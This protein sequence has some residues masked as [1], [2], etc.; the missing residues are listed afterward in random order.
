MKKN[1]IILTVLIAMTITTRGQFGTSLSTDGVHDYVVVQDNNALDLTNN[2]TIECWIQANNVES[3]SLLR[4][5]WCNGAD[6]SYYLSVFSGK[7]E[8]GWSQSGN[9]NYPSWYK[10]IDTVVQEGVC[11]HI[12]IVHSNTEVKIYIDN[13]LVPGI[14]ENGNYS[15]VNNSSEQMDIA[16]YRYLSGAYGNFYCG[17]IDEIRFWNYKLTQLEISD[18]SN[19]P[20]NGTEQGLVAYFD[21]EDTGQGTTLTVTNKAIVSGSIIGQAFGTLSSPQFINSC[22]DPIISSPD[23][24][25]ANTGSNHTI[26][27]QTGTVTISGDPISLGDYIG[28]FF[29]DAGNYVC[30]GYS[31]WTG[32]PS[33]AIAA[34][35]DDTSTPD[36]DGFFSNE[37]F[38]WKVWRATD[39]QV[40][41]MTATY[42]TGFPNGGTYSTNGMS[43]IATMTGTAIVI[44]LDAIGAFTD[45]LCFGGATGMIDITPSGG[46]P[47]YSYIWSN[48]ATTQDLTGLYAGSYSITII[49]ASNGSQIMP[50]SFNNTGANHTILLM[51]NTITI[52]GSP[53]AI[54]DYVGVF[55]IDGIDTVC[56]GYATWTGS[57]SNAVSAWGDDTSTPDKDGF[58][59]GETFIWRIWKA[60]DGAIVNMT[61]IYSPGFPNTSTYTTNGMS[62]IASLTGTYTPAVGA[63]VILNFTISAPDELLISGTITDYGGFGVSGYESIDGGISLN[64]TGGTTPYFYLWSNNFTTQDI[65]NIGSGQYDVTVTDTHGCSS[66]SNFILDQPMAQT[67]V[68]PYYWSIFS[69]YLIPVNTNIANVTQPILNNLYIIKDWMGQAYWPQYG[70][71]LIG[72]IYPGQGFQ[73]KM[74]V[75]DT[76]VIQGT[77]IEA[78]NTPIVIPYYWSILGYILT[79]PAPIEDVLLPVYNNISIVKDWIGQPYW[80]QYSINLIGNMIPGHGYQIKMLEEDTLTFLLIQAPT[81]FVCGDTIS[82]YDGNIYNTVLIGTQCWMKENLKTTHYADGT[83]MVDGTNAGNI[84][85]NYSTKYYFDYNNNPVNTTFY[86]KLYTWAAVMNEATPSNTVPSGVQGICPIGWHVPSDEEWKI[87]EGEVDS[88]YSYPNSVWNN[89]GYRGYDAGEN[90]KAT[91]GW[92]SNGN[93]NDLYGFSAL[94]S[95][96]RYSNGGFYNLGNSGNW[97]SSSETSTSGAVSREVGNSNSN[98]YRNFYS[99]DGGGSVRCL[100]D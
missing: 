52:S 15:T 9:C 69:T 83:S 29:L 60:S 10:T 89:T 35:G 37:A 23:W 39:G 96:R 91:N 81:Q 17:T 77:I 93:G 34:W 46:V 99:K 50:W 54:G 25:F 6:N 71:N 30:G 84:N 74:L 19:S 43:S 90:M 14:L 63:S 20:L 95:G 47:P 65:T 64:V 62:A 45:V 79:E 26:L 59:A 68:L 22:G 85:A 41:D 82:D 31:L 38:N 87:L 44:P 33:N 56:G 94:P 48:G 72:D 97:G 100:K 53:I 4:K 61:T 18:Y 78:E 75:E 57:G 92:N 67:I 73:I 55:F 28:V 36:K 42:S 88:Q 66:T 51:P 86:G 3:L 16:A 12:S 5:G 76:L 27:V 7:V 13:I 40:V 58:S 49:D 32:T 70:V 11:T 8:W 98:V 2:F 80:P 1:T 21:M 24:T